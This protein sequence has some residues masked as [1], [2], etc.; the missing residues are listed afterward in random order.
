MFD[1]V[2]DRWE[3]TDLL[4]APL[5]PGAS[6]AYDQLSAHFQSVSLDRFSFPPSG[7]PQRVQQ[8][9]VIAQST[10]TTLQ[11]VTTTTQQP[12]T[13]MQRTTQHATAPTRTAEL[14]TDTTQT[15]FVTPLASSSRILLCT[16]WLL[17]AL[18]GCLVV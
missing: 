11:P 8:T 2:A 12:T 17:V 16:S 3:Q 6:D 14:V 4:T 18:L 5:S 15:T 9:T 1:L 10:P 7:T 13:T